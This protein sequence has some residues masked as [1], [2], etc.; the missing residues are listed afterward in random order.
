MTH[1]VPATFPLYEFDNTN[2]PALE[3]RPARRWFSSFNGALGSPPQNVTLG[4]S[5]GNTT[6]LVRTDGRPPFDQLDARTSA[7]HVALGGDE[8]PIPHRPCAATDTFAAMA[9]IAAA[10]DQWTQ[11][12]GVL[13]GGPAAE[14]ISWD[15]FTLGYLE[16]DHGSIFIAA[17]HLEPQQ[18]KVRKVED[19]SPYDVDAS[20]SF[21]L[22]TLRRP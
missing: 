4:W 11:I 14:T 13:H 5:D 22:S 12:A 8:L 7:A 15:G 6:T 17:V 3:Y 9:Q 2:H 1:F 16:L 18:F 10:H 19:W 21:P 20:T